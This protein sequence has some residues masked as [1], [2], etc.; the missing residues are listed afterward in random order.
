MEP[1]QQFNILYWYA[2]VAKN[3]DF[4]FCLTFNN[5]TEKVCGLT[6]YHAMN[7]ASSMCYPVLC[8]N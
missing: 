5:K 8:L 6:G 4:T 2:Y 7:S 1:Y 3:G